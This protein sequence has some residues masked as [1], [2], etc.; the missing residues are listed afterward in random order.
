MDKQ[1]PHADLSGRVGRK[2]LP[3][4]AGRLQRACI[5]S[6]RVFHRNCLGVFCGVVLSQDAAQHKMSVT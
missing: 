3:L 2:F 1:S 6:E 5:E 4:A